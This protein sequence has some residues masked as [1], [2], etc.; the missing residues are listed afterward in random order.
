MQVVDEVSFPPHLGRRG[1][2]NCRG[3]A[4]PV[5]FAL[6]PSPAGR[7]GGKKSIMFV[8]VAGGVSLPPHT[9]SRGKG[10]VRYFAC[11]RQTHHVM[12]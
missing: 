3:P 1:R 12:R 11:S 2:K 5:T 9:G 6:S 7:K 10:I 4:P 8:Q